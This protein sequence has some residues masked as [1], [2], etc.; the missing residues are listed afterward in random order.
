MIA[1]ASAGCR[2]LACKL[3]PLAGTV[4]IPP[5]IRRWTR[6]ATHTFDVTK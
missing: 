5:G 3:M 4:D 1:T 6:R 2:D